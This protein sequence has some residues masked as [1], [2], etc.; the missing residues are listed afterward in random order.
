MARILFIED[1]DDFRSLY[2]TV[3]KSAGYE[4]EEASDGSS[5]WEKVHQGGY[6]LVILDIILPQ[7]D[8]ITILKRLKTELPLQP[9][10]KIIM[11]TALSDDQNIKEALANGADG[12]LM[13]A[14]LTPNQV[15]TEIHTI[16]SS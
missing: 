4:V 12:Y 8:G 11:L 1:E 14:S 9:N 2:S 3:L 6:D 5:G 16:L 13:K 15:L 10:K 7:M